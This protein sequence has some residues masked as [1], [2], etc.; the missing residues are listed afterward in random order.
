M[1]IY[2]ARTQKADEPFLDSLVGQDCWIK[3][4]RTD[5]KVTNDFWYVRIL[6]KRPISKYRTGLGFKFQGASYDVWGIP[7]Q[8]L[9]SETLP[10]NYTD[11]DIGFYTSK[12]SLESCDVV[13]PI[14]SYTTVEIF[15]RDVNEKNVSW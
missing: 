6:S 7:A 11:E 13:Y 14:E 1:K 12:F 10:L 9:E 8:F 5:K 2:C 15:G 3:I 4:L